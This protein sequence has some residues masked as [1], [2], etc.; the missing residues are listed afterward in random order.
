VL[1]RLYCNC[2][3]PSRLTTYAAV[4]R[5]HKAGV[6]RTMGRRPGAQYM[7]T[8]PM[9]PYIKPQDQAVKISL[10]RPTSSGVDKF[11]LCHNIV[12][13]PYLRAAFLRARIKSKASALYP[14]LK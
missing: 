5:A 11:E 12:K 10:N 8:H 6:H 7:R 3:T 1:S 13:S 4:E 14:N 2:L 9:L